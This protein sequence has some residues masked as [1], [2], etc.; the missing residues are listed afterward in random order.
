MAVS[1][2][3]KELRKLRIDHD[4]SAA[5]D[6]AKA[7]GMGTAR[8][9]KIENFGTN[10]TA[11][12]LDRV[13]TTYAANDADLA[14]AIRKAAAVSM[15]E[16]AFDMRELSDENRSRVYALWEQ[17]FSAKGKTQAEPQGEGGFERGVA[18]ASPEGTDQVPNASA[19]A[20]QSDE[21]AGSEPA[22]EAEGNDASETGSAATGEAPE[23]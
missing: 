3:G 21:G 12:E 15:P 11:E 7:L 14:E 16:V 18:P 2:L 23:A 5:A 19:A 10:I 1:P 13:I 4:I 8:L 6:M 20:D 22:G 17:L 9:S